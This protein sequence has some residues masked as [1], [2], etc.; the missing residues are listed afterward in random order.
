MA[1][2]KDDNSKPQA[3]KAVRKSPSSTGTV[4]GHGYRTA[5]DTP[6]RGVESI[7]GAGPGDTANAGKRQGP[8]LNRDG[9]QQALKSARIMPK[10]GSD[11]GGGI[12]TLTDA[13]IGSA[14][15][16]APATPGKSP[17]RLGK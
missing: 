13:D 11:A 6:S 9:A 3:P 7:K 12:R 15:G 10:A 2:F 14:S 8:P 17:S 16:R 4:L 1:Q 5:G